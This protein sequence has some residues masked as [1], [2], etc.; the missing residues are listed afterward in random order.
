M[1]DEESVLQLASDVLGS[2]GYEVVGAADGA[3]ALHRFD[4]A[5]AEGRPFDAVVL[6]LT[7]PGGMG[8]L[9]A[10]RL[11]L[12]RCPDLRLVVSSGYTDDPVLAD[13]ARFGFRAGVAK[14]WRVADLARTLRRVLG[15][16]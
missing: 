9:E 15:E 8:G 12:A 16:G 13:P 3:A 14:P 10:A 4:E 7:V 11:L 6:D 1:D 2:L 5:R